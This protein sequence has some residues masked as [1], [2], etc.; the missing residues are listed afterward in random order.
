MKQS[1]HF[2]AQTGAVIAAF[3]LPASARAAEVSVDWPA[4]WTVSK[5]AA[6]SGSEGYRLRAILP[7][8]NNKPL[9]VIELT[10]LK[11]ITSGNFN[12]PVEFHKVQD[13][14][15]QGFAQLNAT[16]SCTASSQTS[17]GG[18]DALETTCTAGKDGANFVKQVIDIG[19]GSEHAYSLTYS[20][21]PNGFDEHLPPFVEVRAK[22]PALN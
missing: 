7:G 5:L 16:V 3:L 17:F 10:V 6:P 11:R 12:L 9:A 8:T 1:V 19:G 14:M 21:S 2:I 15:Q 13:A 20:A 22:L 18:L 4:G